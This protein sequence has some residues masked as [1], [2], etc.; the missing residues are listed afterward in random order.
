M[1]GLGL[2][3]IKSSQNGK[4]CQNLTNRD[5]TRSKQVGTRTSYLFISVPDKQVR[6]VWL[7]QSALSETSHLLSDDN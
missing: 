5:V 7:M 1:P 6:G 4:K 3:C 2:S